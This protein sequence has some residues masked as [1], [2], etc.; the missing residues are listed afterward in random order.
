VGASSKILRKQEEKANIS[1]DTTLKLRRQI[2]KKLKRKKK[3]KKNNAK[4]QGPC[5]NPTKP[6]AYAH[7]QPSANKKYIPDFAPESK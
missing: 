2:V 1:S 5:T 4:G 7:L 3:K 6:K